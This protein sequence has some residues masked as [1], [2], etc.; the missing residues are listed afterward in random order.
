[1]PQTR[2]HILLAAGRWGVPGDCGVLEQVRTWW[3]TRSCWSWWSW[4]VREL[5]KSYQFSGRFDWRVIK[6]LGAARL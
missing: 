2:E 4:K 1:M 3:K 5:L 6:G